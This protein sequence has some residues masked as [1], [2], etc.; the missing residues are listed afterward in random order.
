MSSKLALGLAVLSFVA[1]GG[2]DQ[3]SGTGDAVD[4]SAIEQE[5]KSQEAAWQKD[6]ASR[7][8]D[9]LN[10]HYAEDGALASPFESLATDA[11][12]R[13]AAL[14]PMTQDPNLKMEFSSDQVR[15][16]KSGDL[17]YTRGHFTLQS[18]DPATKQARTDSGSY[19]TVWQ[20]QADGSW[21]AVEDFVVPGKPAA[22]S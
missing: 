19:L 5:L 15:V 10:A 20:K 7:N 14:L 2:C 4:V 13:K 21:K 22:A 6:Y 11:A 3:R 9:A 12:A 16:G 8:V 17:A 18:T 1:L